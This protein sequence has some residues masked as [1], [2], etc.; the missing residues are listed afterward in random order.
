MLIQKNQFDGNLIFCV[1]WPRYYFLHEKNISRKD[2]CGKF[3]LTKDQI[4]RGD[5]DEK[6]YF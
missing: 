1:G 6:L 5:F 4:K 3:L 2:F